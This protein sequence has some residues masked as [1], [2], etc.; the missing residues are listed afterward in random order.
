M[1]SI[2]KQII[3]G[4]REVFPESAAIDF[5]LDSTLG[6]LPEWDS[7]AAVNLQSYLQQQFNTQVPLELLTDETTLEEVTAFLTNP[8]GSEAV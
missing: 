4:I 1:D 7:M 5:T 8:V 6:R 2:F 3:D